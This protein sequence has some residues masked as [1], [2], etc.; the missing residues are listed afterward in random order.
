MYCC[1]QRVCE[2][3]GVCVSVT[4]KLHSAISVLEIDARHECVIHPDERGTEGTGPADARSGRRV[5]FAAP[6]V[7]YHRIV[8]TREWM[9]SLLLARRTH[10]C[11]VQAGKP[12]L[13]SSQ[14]YMY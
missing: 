12:S 5:L 6:Y 13:H 14:E 2:V 4:V 11:I 9:P 3:C 10:T 7:Y 1:V 8:R